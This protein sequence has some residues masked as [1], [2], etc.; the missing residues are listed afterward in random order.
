MFA[1]LSMAEHRFDA[2]T[3]HIN[4]NTIFYTHVEH[5]LIKAVYKKYYIKKNVLN[6]TNS[7]HLYMYR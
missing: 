6:V 2:H 3:I 5:S 7:N 4:L 1:A